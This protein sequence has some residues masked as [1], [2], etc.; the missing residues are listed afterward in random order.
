MVFP[1]LMRIP[2]KVRQFLLQVS[3]SLGET[4]GLSDNSVLTME[5]SAGAQTNRAYRLEKAYLRAHTYWAEL[6]SGGYP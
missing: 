5:S 1:W 4:L 2:T 3:R 6:S